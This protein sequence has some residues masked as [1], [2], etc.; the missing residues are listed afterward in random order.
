MADVAV[1][2]A[3]LSGLAMAV[4]LAGPAARM[5]L[6]VQL[7]DAGDPRDYRSAAFDDRASAITLTSRRML[8]ALGVWQSLDA[9]A[10]PINESIVTDSKLDSPP[11]VH[12]MLR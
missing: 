1:T 12:P 4:A 2:G 7:I 6:K 10:Q 11:S 3:G 8:E 9:K 5:P